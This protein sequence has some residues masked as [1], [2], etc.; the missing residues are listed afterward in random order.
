MVES[1]PR[2]DAPLALPATGRVVVA[3]ALGSRAWASIAL[4]LIVFAA[5]WLRLVA[6]A[7]VDGNPFYD[8]AV[9][10]MGHSL[11]DFFYGAFEPSGS[12]SIDKPP[13]DLW[14]Q[15]ASVK[16]L[17]FS[18]TALKLPEALAGTLSVALLY[19]TT[20]RV[21]GVAAGLGAALALAVLPVA[22]LTS[23]S[24]T[25]DAVMSLLLIAALW[26]LVR[27]AQT[28]R[29]RWVLVAA[30]CVGVAFNVKLLEAV[31]PV[32]ALAAGAW[33]ALPGP[34]R[35]RATTTVAAACVMVAISLSWLTAGSL[36]GSAPYAI[37]STNGS[38]WNAA[39]VFNGIDR[40]GASP[41]R[42]RQPRRHMSISPPGPVR[43]L[44]RRGQ[45][46]VTRLGLELLA[47]VA[48]GLPALWARRR[49]NRAAFAV[50]VT[51][52]LWLVT[53]ATLFSAMSRL[54][55]RYTEAVNPAIAACA[56][57]GVAWLGHVAGRRLL[58]AGAV[59]VALAA[60]ALWATGGSSTSAIGLAATTAGVALVV[61]TALWPRV[62][63]VTVA[64]FASLGVA[65]AMA[66]LLAAPAAETVHVVAHHLSDSGHP[67]E[68]PRSRVRDLS[69][70][71]HD[72]QDGA[73]YE[74]ASAAATQAGPLIARDGRPVLIL[75]SFNGQPLVP[76]A[77]L[78]DLVAH[79]DVRYA[80]LGAASCRSGNPAL[81]VCSPAASWVRHHGI[82]ISSRADV[83][84]GL[85][86][87]LGRPA[88]LAR[89]RVSRSA[90]ARA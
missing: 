46:P 17:G 4:A 34:T 61:W 40:I 32:P 54:H 84:P 29:A 28:G 9:R 80:L 38:A 8:A 20:R 66:G 33:I 3:P 48:L 16:L 78:T 76:I 49:E 67:G 30:A 21:F 47:A 15:V 10:S 70:Y 24:D 6:L 53:G 36:V 45:L 74:F 5:G 51:L 59:A 90:G 27:T 79:G 25:M 52:A 44:A 72:H 87:E 41:V 19:D 62:P 50:G 12:V 83:Y 75:T 11:R 43:L 73:R 37:G 69:N 2:L 77:R 39:F 65:L 60:F 23:R 1:Q 86:W 68:M 63:R 88:E 85:V 31:V 71:L 58:V 55:P 64:R 81:A 7:K 18:G 13:I 82:D 26:S 89:S 57:I 14:L 22:V 56:G 35:R 42:N